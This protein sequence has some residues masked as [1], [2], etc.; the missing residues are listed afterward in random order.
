MGLGSPQR[1]LGF[2][3]LL[4]MSFSCDISPLFSSFLG[5][6]R[7][8]RRERSSFRCASGDFTVVVAPDLPEP[9]ARSFLVKSSS[10]PV[11]SRNLKFQ[12]TRAF[13]LLSVSVRLWPHTMFRTYIAN[14]KPS[15]HYGVFQLI[16][17]YFSLRSCSR[18]TFYKCAHRPQQA[19]T[20]ENPYSRIPKP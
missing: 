15:V 5:L 18:E 20:L 12:R 14:R 1:D 7:K 2:R 16:A 3:V 13:R 11:L 17:E 10:T 19:R 6:F 9:D 4:I 8:F